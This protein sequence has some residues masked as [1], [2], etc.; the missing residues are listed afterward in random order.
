[1]ARVGHPQVQ[2]ISDA[3]KRPASEGGPYG[4]E[5][6]AGDGEEE[7]KST[8]RSACATGGLEEFDG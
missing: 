5:E 8:G 6:V 3:R 1:M 4:F 2:L 7:P